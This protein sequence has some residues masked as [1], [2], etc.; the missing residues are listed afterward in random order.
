MTPDTM[1]EFEDE[2]DY[3]RVSGVRY[4]DDDGLFIWHCAQR[5]HADGKEFTCD[6]CQNT[7]TVQTDDG[8]VL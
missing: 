4:R 2:T 8:G 3:E 5:V 1:Q 6:V 7:I